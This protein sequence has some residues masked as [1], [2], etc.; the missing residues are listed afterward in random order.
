MKIFITGICGFVGSSLAHGLREAMPKAKI[1]GIDNL[2]RPGSEINRR[3]LKPFGIS[4]VHGDIRN[5]SD[6]EPL[7]PADWII[8]AAANPSVMAGIDGKT[9]S[10]QL[11][12]HNLMGTVNVLELCRKWSCGLIMISTSR[13]YS[14]PALAN[15]KMKVSDRAFVPAPQ[16]LR[17][18]GM[19]SKGIT[20][21]FSMQSPVS[22]YGATKLASECLTMEYG[23]TYG[24]P[25]FIN[26]C[27][28]MAGAG[29]FGK[30]DQGIFSYWIHS[31]CRK[32]PLRYIGFNGRGYQ[33]RDCLHPRD[34]VSLIRRQMARP[35][36]T[37]VRILNVSGGIDNSISLAQLSSW[38]AE[39][40]GPHHIDARPE[41]RPFD[42]PWLVLNAEH[43]RRVWNWTPATSLEQIL[44]EIARHSEQ[45]PH[46]LEMCED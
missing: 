36:A 3:T 11:V 33:V 17:V 10:R 21:D 34:I 12:E 9:S 13:V 8:D 41:K 37:A 22:L 24:L 15:L 30:T 7:A 27:G 42:I 43:A 35:H 29:Q 1:S 23:A 5:A 19:T 32:Q 38:C 25:V 45:N 4:V 6:L 28:V 14:I 16:S 2:V 44:E 18:H 20:E 46:W 40:F 31:Y 39:R 26:R